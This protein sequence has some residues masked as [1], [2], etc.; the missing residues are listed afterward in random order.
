MLPCRLE[1]STICPRERMLP[2]KSRRMFSIDQPVVALRVW[3]SNACGTYLMIE[4][5]SF[6]Y[7]SVYT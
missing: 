6:M 5:A 7:C 4:M 2:A 3:L 1:S